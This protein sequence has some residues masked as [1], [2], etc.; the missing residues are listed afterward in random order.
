[1][2]NVGE[3]IEDFL[4]HEYDPVKARAYYLRTRKLKGRKPGSVESEKRNAA[5]AR[6]A[7]IQKLS[8]QRK[9]LAESKE[10]VTSNKDPR[11]VQRRIAQQ[12]KRLA[13]AKEKATRIKDPVKRNAIERK[14][15]AFEAKL[16]RV[17]NIKNPFGKAKLTGPKNPFEGAKLS[18]SK[19]PRPAS[20][21]N[22]KNPFAGAK[23]SRSNG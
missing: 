12:R 22:L 23:I 13:E 21:Y 7:Q 15:A 2:T 17:R 5:A 19:N 14:L 20:D 11:E 3:F 9:K 1:M 10:K 18:R 4:E 8:Q 6:S 16:D